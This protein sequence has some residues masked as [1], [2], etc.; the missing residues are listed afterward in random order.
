M[1]KLTLIIPIKEG[2]AQGNSLEKKM[3]QLPETACHNTIAIPGGQLDLLYKHHIVGVLQYYVHI[4]TAE[5]PK[6][7]DQYSTT[8][9]VF[10]AYISLVCE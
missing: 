8:A 2:Q 10:K 5:S 7:L 9:A 1:T 6:A 4:T 3:Q